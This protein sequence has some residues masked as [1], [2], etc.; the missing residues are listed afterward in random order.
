MLRVFCF[1]EALGA[2]W[3]H[4]GLS[5]SQKTSR[6]P[7][8]GLSTPVL[9]SVGNFAPELPM[10]QAGICSFSFTGVSP[11]TFLAQ[12]KP[13]LREPSQGTLMWGFLRRRT[14]REVMR[15]G[16]V[17]NPCSVPAGVMQILSGKWEVSLLT[18]HVPRTILCWSRLSSQAVPDP[19]GPH[20]LV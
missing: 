7:P 17:P 10:G 13:L 20:A 1:H 5:L 2:A 11:N 12:V 6:T 4:F 9:L 3:L 19:C 8:G 16:F 15:G 18:P 14:P